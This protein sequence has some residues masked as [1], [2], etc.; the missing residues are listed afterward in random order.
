MTTSVVQ[1]LILTFIFVI[2]FCSYVNCDS[3]NKSKSGKAR[4][5]NRKVYS[6]KRFGPIT[7]N[8]SSTAEI[9]H[10]ENITE[11]PLIFDAEKRKKEGLPPVISQSVLQQE[12]PKNQCWMNVNAQN[13]FE[14]MDGLDSRYESVR[15]KYEEAIKSD[16]FDKQMLD[17]MLKTK[18]AAERVS[19]KSSGDPGFIP[20]GINLGGY[21][22]MRLQD[23]IL[24]FHRMKLRNN[25]HFRV[26]VLHNDL[27]NM[28]LTAKLSLNDLHILGAYER[29]ITQSDPSELFYKPTFGEVEFL[30]RNVQYNME[31][32]YRL[33]RNKLTIELVVSDITT[34][35]ILMTYQNNEDTT[36][37]ITLQR[38]NIDEF[39]DR[40]KTDLDKWLKDYFN[41]YLMY[42]GLEGSKANAEL[43][44][45]EK[46]KTLALD[47]YTDQVLEKM[48]KRLLELYFDAVQ[49]P[50]FTVTAVTG[51][52][53]KLTKGVLRGLDTIHRR[54]LATC[55][56]EDKFRKIDMTIGFSSLQAT[57]HYEAVFN[58]GVPPINGVLFVT[59]HELIAHM[60]LILTKNPETLNI[61]IDSLEQV[62][63]ESITVEGP[64]NRIIGNFK[65]LLERH[66]F[67]FISNAIIHNVKMISTIT[68]CE[69][70][71][72]AFNIEEQTLSQENEPNTDNRNK[73][74]LSYK[75]EEQI[76]ETLK[77]TN[78]AESNEMLNGSGNDATNIEISIDK[79]EGDAAPGSSEEEIE[80]ENRSNVKTEEVERIKGPMVF[81]DEDQSKSESSEIEKKKKKNDVLP[82]HK[83]K[84]NKKSSIFI[85]KIPG[86]KNEK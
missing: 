76:N 77:Q 63:P 42:F 44:E 1:L 21:S 16:D 55:K 43:L 64:A 4:F 61:V 71:L 79:H 10:Q 54:G 48:K 67:T 6:R 15:K 34:N 12:Y 31:G 60:G 62:K 68:Q 25:T 83:Q 50:K 3:N 52:Q 74:E 82:K 70:R 84:R 59:A 41:D 18:G 66:I 33:L 58:T 81:S 57:Y 51:M 78:E 22:M 39:L 40:L 19:Q 17:M 32:R 2:I 53:M 80:G 20:A 5:L 28:V 49:I 35:D 72:N 14:T 30:L 85:N 47:D 8:N 73:N 23:S 27:A 56:R 29:L 69:P 37:P 36:K 65:N 11:A 13:H 46:E 24:F 38:K 26:D 45:Y 7:L 9:I 86:R 75:N